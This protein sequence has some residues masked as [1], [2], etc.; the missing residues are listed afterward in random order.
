LPKLGRCQRV[1]RAC[2]ATCLAA[3]SS[4]VMVTSE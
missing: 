4:T 2:S 3:R 1:S